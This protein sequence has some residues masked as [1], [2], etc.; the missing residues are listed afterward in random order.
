M[1][2]NFMN[3]PQPSNGKYT[4]LYFDQYESEQRRPTL[5]S[6]GLE[7]SFA[8]EKINSNSQNHFFD[9]RVYNLCLRDVFI[10][11]VSKAAKQPITWV[12]YCQLINK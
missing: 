3:Y 4:Q 9:C 12:E 7:V 6:S 1:P 5:N 11:I 10:H 2:E 8:W